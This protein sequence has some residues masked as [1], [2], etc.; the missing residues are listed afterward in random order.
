[1][2]LQDASIIE[3]GNFAFRPNQIGQQ[4]DIG[5]WRLAMASP[6]WKFLFVVFLSETLR[7]VSNI[8][9]ITKQNID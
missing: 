5:N 7:Y 6:L 8:T 2:V 1:M 9:P 3:K 4:Q